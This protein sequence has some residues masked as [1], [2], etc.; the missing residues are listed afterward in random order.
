MDSFNQDSEDVNEQ[1]QITNLNYN[2]T[3]DETRNE[4]VRLYINSTSVSA[5]AEKFVLPRSTVYSIIAKYNS[6]GDPSKAKNRNKTPCKLTRGIRDSIKTMVDNN[7]AITLKEIQRDL[8]ELTGVFLSL[9]SINTVISDFCYSLKNIVNVPAR[10]NSVE[11]IGRRYEYALHFS[12]L[13]QNKILFVDE[14]GFSI[15]TRRKKGRSLLGTS[16]IRV[17]RQIRSRNLSVCSA[18]TNGGMLDYKLMFKAFNTIS[19][20]E[21]IRALIE[22]LERNRCTGFSF[23]MDN[24]AFHS[25]SIIRSLIEEAGHFC[26]Y[27][28]PYS[29]FLNPIEEVFSKWKA[30][31]RSL[32][33]LTEDD[34]VDGIRLGFRSITNEDIQGYMAHVRSYFPACLNKEAINQ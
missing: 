18:V 15:C 12:K 1:D 5:I 21:F 31:V 13:D 16:P 19:Y 14:T 32:N 17:V 6:T 27:L 2:T 10:R 23:I 11:V 8:N 34:L 25:S 20:A 26:V 3:N 24:V 4:I 28:P 33:I 30:V 22:N 9:T 29:P 7:A